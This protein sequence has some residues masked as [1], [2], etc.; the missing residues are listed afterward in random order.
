[1]IV[2]SPP[3][4]ARTLA[5]SASPVIV[6]AVLVIYR[7][8]VGSYFFND[9]F[10]WLQEHW[11][12]D[13]R[14]LFDLGHYSH[15]YRPVIQIYFYLSSTAFGCDATGFHLESVAV[16]LLNVWLLYAIARD[17]TRQSTFA[18]I[19]ALL[20]AVQPGYVEAVAWVGA[21]TDL[22]P[23]TWML[24]ALWLHLRFLRDRHALDYALSL[25]VFA[26]CLL[27]HETS[28]VL[29]PMMVALEVALVKQR[30]DGRPQESLA[31]RAMR[32]AP[33]VVMLTGSLAVA[34]VVNRRSYIV[35]EGHYA[36]GW[37]V[38]WNVLNDVVGLY[39]G[40]HNGWSYVAIVVAFAAAFWRGGWTVRF[41]IVWL[42]IAAAPSSLFTWGVASRYLYVP[43][44]AFSLM[45]AAGM[46]AVRDAVAR[47]GSPSWGNRMA[48]ALTIAI[49]ARFA[50]FAAGGSSDFRDRTQPYAQLAAAVHAARQSSSSDS[51]VLP[52]AD[53]D[54]IPDI[55]REPAVRV[56]ACSPTVTLTVR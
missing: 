4:P 5:F 25:V 34:F 37:H 3:G 53:F 17:L 13:F 46:L 7:A 8:A 35:Q 54:N 47:R 16:H 51:V 40:K 22:L 12:F 45:L 42:L 15:F 32:Y 36:I 9:D 18:A 55:Y 39:V 31:R 10:Q 49:A 14:S 26:L 20:F 2:T 43:A 11:A 21:I 56:A 48:V 50:V 52:A 23:A 1:M 6:V 30:L 24:L 29:W 28:S 44:A 38:I 33:F 41:A 27:T 19:A